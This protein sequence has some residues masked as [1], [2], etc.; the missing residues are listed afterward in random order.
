MKK[1]LFS[2]L[3][4]VLTWAWA[5]ENPSKGVFYEIFVRSFQDSDGDGIGD[6]NGIT[7]RLDYLQDLGITGIW[8]MPVNPSPSYHGYDVTDY[9][10]VNADY[11][12]LDDFKTLLE[13]AH[14]RGIQVIIDLVVN[15][16]SDQHPWFLKA[17]LGQEPY[18]DYY[19]WQTED[20]GW[21]GV[22][23]S[24]AWHKTET[25]YYLG[26]FW[27]GMPDLNYRNP[28]IVQEMKNVA[29]FWLEL[30]V[31]G[32]RIDAIQHVLESESGNIRNVPETFAWLEDFESFIKTIN[33]EAFLVGETW[34][35]TETI[36]K[37]HSQS[38]LDM[39]FNYPLYT[40]VLAG[41]Q[42]RS[43]TDLKFALD[44]DNRL[45]PENSQKAIFISNHDQVRPA[46]SLSPLRRDVE[47]LKL[48]AG[49]LLSLPGTPFIYYGEEIGMPNGKE[50]KDEAKRTP[51][52]W[53][54]NTNAGFSEHNPWYAF[55]TEDAAISVSAESKNA[56]SL[57][58]HYKKLIEL[59]TQNP[60]LTKG[61]LELIDLSDSSVLA[62]RR[63][64]GFQDLVIVANF[65]NQEKEI[66]LLE[67]GLSGNLDLISE[68]HFTDTLVLPK[69][70]LV[71]LEP[72]RD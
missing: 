18:R 30:G 46:T 39:S 61:S 2:F 60:A 64:S 47:R 58:N 70:G 44:Q 26:L 41:I 62:F 63:S 15:H 21:R 38:H 34:T 1:L 20:P 27:S 40:A 5:Q 71:V 31:D 22:S 69:L 29:Q 23:G 9:Y 24:P 59:R 51:M 56:N 17:K 66:S 4:L 16:T 37:Y 8:L 28:A 13:S 10:A 65:S 43:A 67:L 12:S 6:F 72:L 45:Y 48:A 35:D 7:E 33:P 57:L 14:E 36:A 3:A 50:D 52:R 11:G 54:E 42:K 68:T 49:L 55:S 53:D 25:G 19:L 32:F